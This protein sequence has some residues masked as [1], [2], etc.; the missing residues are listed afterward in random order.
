M[1]VNCSTL[2]QLIFSSVAHGNF[3][4][5]SGRYGLKIICF[6]FLVLGFLVSTL[7]SMENVQDLEVCHG[8]WPRVDQYRL[9]KAKPWVKLKVNIVQRGWAKKMALTKYLLCLRH[10]SRHIVSLR[11]PGL[12][13][14]SLSFVSGLG[15]FIICY[16]LIKITRGGRKTMGL[17]IHALS[18]KI[19]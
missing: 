6:S 7:S 19:S 18:K 1:T 15:A 5:I 8:I 16:P 12:V 13:S 2:T 10:C 11:H 17:I 9:Q 3:L 4:L 14:Q